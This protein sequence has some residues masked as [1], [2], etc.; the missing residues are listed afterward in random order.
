V[1]SG[2]RVLIEEA[3]GTVSFESDKSGGGYKAA[4]GERV[5]F[6]KQKQAIRTKL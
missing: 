3:G 2:P 5:V 4:S 6:D 1:R